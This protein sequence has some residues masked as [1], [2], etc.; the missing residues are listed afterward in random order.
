M[1]KYIRFASALFY[2]RIFRKRIPLLVTLCLTNRCNLRCTYCY[3]EYYDR[4][5]QEPST[6]QLLDL[7]DTLFRM[8]TRY[9]SLN[10]GE[11]LLR[12][13]IEQIVDKIK[14]KG[15]LCHLSTNGL[16]VYSKIDILRKMDSIAISL[17]GGRESND[18]NRGS[19]VYD[20]VIQAFETLSRAGIHFHT[21]T[22]LTKNNL[23]AIEEVLSLAVKFGFKAQFSPL[24]QEDSPDKT[25]ALDDADLRSVVQRILDAQ[26]QGLGVFFSREAYLRVLNW[27]FPYA[28]Y[29]VSQ[30]HKDLIGYGRCYLKDLSCHIEANGFVYPCIVLVNK[31]KP[32]NVWEDGFEAVWDSLG[33]ISCEACWNVCC[34]QMN[35]VFSLRPLVFYNIISIISTRLR[36]QKRLPDASK[37]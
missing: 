14:S 28:T 29:S 15:I 6:K 10:G 7:I 32:L 5:H 37:L 18:K 35:L 24:R 26:K 13:D 36:G 4:N 8:G 30:K 11:A 34:N 22:V 23:Q 9:I 33:K 2:A 16:L 17:D 27:P 1:I 19:G 25:M 31:S 21:H 20:Q 3:E 12:K